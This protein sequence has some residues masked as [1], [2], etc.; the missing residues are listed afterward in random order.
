MNTNNVNAWFSMFTGE[1]KKLPRSSNSDC[2]HITTLYRNGL[3]TYSC[4]KCEFTRM[5][6][7]AVFANEPKSVMATFDN[8]DK[9]KL[10]ALLT[11][12]GYSLVY[13]YNF[14]LGI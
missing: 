4:E 6:Y 7:L 12:V 8:I 13:T 3:A 10:H 9:D 1:L 14:C 5:Y 11:G 2:T